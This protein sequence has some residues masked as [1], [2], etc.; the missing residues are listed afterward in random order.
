MNSMNNRQ[1]T[2]REITADFNNEKSFEQMV[3]ET[4]MKRAQIA[5]CIE[6]NKDKLVKVHRQIMRNSMIA[7]YNEAIKYSYKQPEILNYPASD[8]KEYG[9]KGENLHVLYL[10]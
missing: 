3:K 1:Q 4:E 2:W 8:D 6:A 7:E 9:G 5:K 10:N